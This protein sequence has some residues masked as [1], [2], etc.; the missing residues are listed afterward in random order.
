MPEDMQKKKKRLSKR[1]WMGLSRAQRERFIQLLKE[2]KLKGL[3]LKLAED[4]E[5]VIVMEDSIFAEYCAR[6]KR[7]RKRKKR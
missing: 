3:G 7:T 6:S 4:G 2:G 1:R 5:N